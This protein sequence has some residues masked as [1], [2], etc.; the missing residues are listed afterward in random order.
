VLQINPER[1]MHTFCLS[2]IRGGGGIGGE[3]VDDIDKCLASQVLRKI[4]HF[5]S[6]D[7]DKTKK[8]WLFPINANIVTI[9]IVDL[10]LAHLK[11]ECDMPYSRLVA[12]AIIISCQTQSPAVVGK[13]DRQLANAD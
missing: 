6:A 9:R 1:H 12:D 13:E 7:K 5:I 8:S 3:Y 4:H 2:T 10:G 11:T